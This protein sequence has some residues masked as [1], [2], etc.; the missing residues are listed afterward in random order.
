MDASSPP[1]C[2]I[3]SDLQRFVMTGRAPHSLMRPSRSGRAPVGNADRAGSAASA[4]GNN[5][6]LQD[7]AMTDDP[8]PLAARAAADLRSVEARSAQADAQSF[9]VPCSYLFFACYRLVFDRP[10]VA[11]H[12][13][14]ARDFTQD[15]QSVPA[16]TPPRVAGR[17]LVF[18]LIFTSSCRN[19]R[20]VRNDPQPRSP[21]ERR[22]PRYPGTR[23]SLRSCGLQYFV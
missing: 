23:M 17:A 21:D 10:G 13:P 15:S 2:G 18:S 22:Q 8:P 6:N 11:S 19:A 20:T 5:R 4:R 16:P 7:R 3:C 12:S 1:N 14:R 9:M